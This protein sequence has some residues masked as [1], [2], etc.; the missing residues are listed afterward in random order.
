MEMDKHVC[1]R[2]VDGEE[3][4]RASLALIQER[5]REFPI[6]LKSSS[7]KGRFI[8]AAKR[9]EASEIIFQVSA[10]SSSS[11]SSSFFRVFFAYF[12]FNSIQFGFAGHPFQFLHFGQLQKESL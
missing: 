7:E 3:S 4:E 6:L 8:V 2:L 11:S 1:S 10:H 5:L 12:H 9:I